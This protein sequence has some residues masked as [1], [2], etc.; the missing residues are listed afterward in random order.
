MAGSHQP[1]AGSW[2]GTS[3]TASAPPASAPGTQARAAPAA[4]V[5]A[6]LASGGATCPA[7]VSSADLRIATIRAASSSTTM[8]ATA[9]LT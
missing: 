4:V 5:P 8:A 1:P 9:R 6:I 2:P 3:S 7:H